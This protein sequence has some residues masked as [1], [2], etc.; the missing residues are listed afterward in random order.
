MLN[1]ASWATTLPIMVMGMVGIF[2]VIGVIILVV[3][4]LGRLML[5]GGAKRKAEPAAKPEPEPGISDET[6]ALVIASVCEE[7]RC[8][9]ENIRITSIRELQ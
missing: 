9:P 8:A 5:A 4:A 3:Y 6:A 1:T 7:L 2:I